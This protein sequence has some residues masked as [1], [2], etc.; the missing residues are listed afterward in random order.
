TGDSPAF[1]ATGTTLR[2]MLNRQG[3]GGPDQV[4]RSRGAAMVTVS[5][6]LP[7]FAQ[8]GTRIDVSLGVLGDA[9]SLQGGILQPTPLEGPDGQVYAVAQGPVSIGGFSASG[10]AQSVTRGVVST[11]HITNGATVER[12]PAFDFG[13]QS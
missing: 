3:V 7:P 9:V 6:V 11:A 13:A 12:M 10:G 8:P 4:I 5:A 2:S 1:P